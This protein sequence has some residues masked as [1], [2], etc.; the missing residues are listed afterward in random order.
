MRIGKYDLKITDMQEGDNDNYAW[1]RA[2]VDVSSN[3]RPIQQMEPE[4]RATKQQAAGFHRFKFAGAS[5]KICT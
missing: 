1:R 3:G 5:M 2:I 4:Q